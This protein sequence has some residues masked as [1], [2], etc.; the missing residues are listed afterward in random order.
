MVPIPNF[1]GDE[2]S[3][4]LPGDFTPRCRMDIERSAA[5]LCA[6]PL[7]WNFPQ[8]IDFWFSHLT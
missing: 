2:A 3:G 7:S 1:T 8:V 4:K 5:R 6:F